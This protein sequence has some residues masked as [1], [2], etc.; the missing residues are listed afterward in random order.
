MEKLKAK[1]PYVFLMM[2]S[3]SFVVFYFRKK[4]RNMM[5]SDAKKAKMIQEVIDEV[6]CEQQKR[7]DATSIIKQ[8]RD[9]R[10]NQIMAFSKYGHQH[11]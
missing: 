7:Y 9:E 10:A 5:M 11:K 3:L 2:A 6:R 8:S 4:I 1:S